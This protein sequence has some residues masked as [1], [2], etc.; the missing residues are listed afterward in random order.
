MSVFSVGSACTVSSVAPAAPTATCIICFE[1]DIDANRGVQCAGEGHHFLCDVCL[2]R[3]V[4]DTAQQVR[5]SNDL[6]AQ[7]VA[8]DAAGDTRRAHLL[9]RSRRRRRSASS[10]AYSTPTSASS[11]SATPPS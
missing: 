5:D 8:A 6:A 1:D 3:I 11:Q 2:E 9:G 4:V 10:L 7:A